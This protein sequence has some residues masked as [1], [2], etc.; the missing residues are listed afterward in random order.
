MTRAA[1][2]FRQPPLWGKGVLDIAF[3]SMAAVGPVPAGF[4][5]PVVMFARIVELPRPNDLGPGNPVSNAAAA[6]VEVV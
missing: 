6:M 2:D 4:K 3:E 1:R 5:G